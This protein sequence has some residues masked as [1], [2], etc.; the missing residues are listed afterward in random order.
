MAVWIRNGAGGK[1]VRVTNV[2]SALGSEGKTMLAA[3]E[4]IRLLGET[5]RDEEV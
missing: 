1:A 5:R 2:T 4:G 3:G